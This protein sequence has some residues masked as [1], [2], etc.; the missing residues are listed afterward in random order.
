MTKPRPQEQHPTTP[1][2]DVPPSHDDDATIPGPTP[3][4][5]QPSP[6][7]NRRQ[8]DRPAPGRD[9]AHEISH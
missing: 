8:S 1:M 9:P 6:A 5:P 4:Q 2:P 3:P 7:R